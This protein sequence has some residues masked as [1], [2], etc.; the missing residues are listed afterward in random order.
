MRLAAFP[1]ARRAADSGWLGEAHDG[2]QQQRCQTSQRDSQANA[3]HEQ[4]PSGHGGGQ[5]AR[6]LPGSNHRV[7]TP[8][9]VPQYP[10]STALPT[11]R[12]P[13]RAGPASVNQPGDRLPR[14]QSPCDTEG[15]AHGLLWRGYCRARWRLRLH[16]C[17]SDQSQLLGAAY[18]FAPAGG[19]ELAEDALEVSLHGVNGEVHRGGDLFGAEH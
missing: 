14:D 15:R 18:C 3:A 1:C 17:R 13:T 5:A 10:R 9:L 12:R 8:D 7:T 19:S 6:D 2:G 4:E 16:A 11:D